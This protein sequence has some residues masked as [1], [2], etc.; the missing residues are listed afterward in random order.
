VSATPTS[1]RAAVVGAGL[2]GRWHAHA[3]H[4]VGSRVVALIDPEVQ[5]AENLAARLP[6]RPAV[7]SDLGVAIRDH[8]VEV[9]HVCSPL[10]T[11]DAVARLAIEA[12][13]P[14][15]VEKPLASDAPAAEALHKLASERGVILCPVHQ[16]LFQPGVL[17]AQ[18]SM[19]ALGALRQLDLVACSAG[20]DGAPDSEREA[21]ALDIL[22]HGLALARRLLAAPLAGADWRVGQGASGEIRA[23]ADV[24]DASVML[25]VSMRARP[26]ENSLTLRFDGGT[27]RANLFHGYA[28]IDR[29]SPSRLD[30][31]G[32]PFV[33]STQTLG[34][35]IGNLVERA[36]RRE[37]AYPGLR[38]LVRRF[39][40][41][42]TQLGPSPISVEESLDVA[43]ARDSIRD[44]RR[45][46]QR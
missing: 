30:K 41:A 32:R 15:L 27:V 1:L 36:V 42:C 19:A 2:M 25:A 45:R 13:I 5:R 9:V 28:T 34:A 46:G 24:A 11:H 26:T 37:P 40:L 3:I 43:H 10:A 21:V 20:A 39:H 44:A 4:H 38:E 18:Q 33:S 14:V 29:G 6:E 12:G 35:A 31:V 7:G 23:M 8:G 17:A 16:F 22:P